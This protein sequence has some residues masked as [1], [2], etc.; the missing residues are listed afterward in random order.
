MLLPSTSSSTVA[1]LLAVPALLI[2]LR[3]IL[4]SALREWTALAGL[5]LGT[6]GT[7][8]MLRTTTVVVVVVDLF[9]GRNWGG[10]FLPEIF[11]DD[12]SKKKQFR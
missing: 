1:P 4:V 12:F 9:L 3:E 6:L 7:L 8:G 10:F 2:I 11:G 5:D